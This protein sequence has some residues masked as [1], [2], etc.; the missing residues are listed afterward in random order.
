[1]KSSTSYGA[2]AARIDSDLFE[3]VSDLGGEIACLEEIT[4]LVS[5]RQVKASF[6]LR[7]KDGRTFKARLYPSEE[8]RRRVHGLLP[9]IEDL[10]FARMIAARGRATLEE[11]VEGDP[12]HA[13]NVTQAQSGRAGE[14]LGLLHTRSGLPEGADAGDAELHRQMAKIEAHLSAISRVAPEQSGMC[15]TIAGIARGNCPEAIE[16]GLIHADYCAENIIVN[17]DGIMVVVD[18]EL[19]RVGALDFD[20]ARCWCRWPMKQSQRRAFISGYER[21]RQM[22]R[23]VA[24]RYFWA[25]RALALSWNVH[26]SHG[27]T[28]R[29]VMS[30]LKRIASGDTA[31]IWPV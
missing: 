10:P 19:L 14:L 26:L 6:K 21:Y 29:P 16:T 15:E 7:L 3:L 24:H 22:E 13:A 28:N 12:L 30:A 8:K 31:R 20:L 17:D 1:M 11:W 27:R 25:I 2:S 9:L 23:F 5:P 4:R 18:N